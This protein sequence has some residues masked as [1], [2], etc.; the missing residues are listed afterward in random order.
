M[1]RALDINKERTHVVLAG[2]KI[3][4]TIRVDGTTCTEDFDLR[5]AAVERASTHGPLY[6]G[7]DVSSAQRETFDIEDVAW[8]N[9]VFS[10][11]IATAA[12]NGKIMLYDMKR[13]DVEV[14]RLHEHYRQVH[15]VD[16]NPIE[17]RFLLSGS[18]D[19]T[20][21][22]WDLRVFRQN[23]MICS[24]STF[25]GRSDGVRHVKWNPIDRWTFAF[26]T[27]NGTIQRWDTRKPRAPILT[28]AAHS[29]ICNSLD[30]HPDGK[31]LVS[32][33]KDCDVKV[34]DMS[35]DGS[36]KRKPA[37]QLRTPREVQNVRW[38]PACLTSDPQEQNSITRQC[39][40]LATS[41]RHM[42]V[43]H[44]WDLRRP[45]MPFREICHKQNTGTT[46]MLWRSK[47]L[48][49]T[50]GPEGDFTQTDVHYAPKVLDRRS[51]QTIA[52]S[53][54]GELAFF[55]SRRPLRSGQGLSPQTESL[56]GRASSQMEKNG[57]SP[58]D[59]SFEEQFLS[60]AFL[61]RHS[62]SPSTAKS[63]RSLAI[64]PPSTDETKERTVTE[65]DLTMQE[66]EGLKPHQLSQRGPLPGTLSTAISIYLAWKYK[67]DPFGHPAGLEPPTTPTL[68]SIA[69]IQEVFER[70]GV[71]AQRAS[72]YREAQTWRIL[73]NTL[74]RELNMR[75]ETNRKQRLNKADESQSTSR[76]ARPLTSYQSLKDQIQGLRAAETSSNVPTP[77]AR[78]VHDATWRDTQGSLTVPSELDS[79]LQLPFSLVGTAHIEGDS[80]EPKRRIT[81]HD[82]KAGRETLIP[83]WADSTVKQEKLALISQW[84]AQPKTPFSF[85]QQL[86]SSKSVTSRAP[87]DRQASEEDI[88][89]PSDSSGSH[90]SLSAGDSFASREAEDGLERSQHD[91]ATHHSS[92]FLDEVS[93]ENSDDDEPPEDPSTFG[94][95]VSESTSSSARDFDHHSRNVR[96]AHK[97]LAG[98]SGS[99]PSEQQSLSSRD[100]KALMEAGRRSS[101]RSGGAAVLGMSRSVSDSIVHTRQFRDVAAQREK[102]LNGAS[103]EKNMPVDDTMTNSAPALLETTFEENK[104]SEELLVSDYLKPIQADNGEPQQPF[105]T[106]QMFHKLLTWYTAQSNFQMASHLIL[107]SLP[108]LAPL[109][110][111]PSSD[112]FLITHEILTNS[113]YN[114][115]ID[116]ESRNALSFDPEFASDVIC[117]R[118]APLQAI[119]ISPMWVE[120][121]LSSY[122]EQ[123]LSLNLITPAAVLR[124]LAYPAFPAVYEQSLRDVQIGMLC[125]KCKNPINNPRDKMRCESCRGRQAECPICWSPE[126][127]YDM[128]ARKREKKPK[129]QGQHGPAA[130]HTGHEFNS[131]EASSGLHVYQGTPLWASCLL[132]GHA[133]HTACAFKWFADVYAH[134]AC[135]TIGCVCDCTTG[136]YRDARLAGMELQERLRSVKKPLRPEDT[137]P[138]VGESKTLNR[139]KGVLRP[140][141]SMS[142]GERDDKE[143]SKRVRM[144]FPGS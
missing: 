51:L 72:L 74:V 49:W 65:L 118:L 136:G 60:A 139:V 58:G 92:S 67:S 33:G 7:D 88:S 98:D 100:Q 120:T 138:A 44:V 95:S 101:D 89:F 113:Y 12:S 52:T 55:T 75:A 130:S 40:H 41:Y 37:Y 36:R 27:D 35:S 144:V 70:N 43:V 122:H 19:G 115:F 132:C 105:S 97:G 9:G 25:P 38:R 143:E 111:A 57:R 84:K 104:D 134:G 16:F 5:T 137:S 34:W 6:A 56:E 13:P 108:L 124:R 63:V 32:A 68:A 50:V 119:D 83:E 29:S 21:R 135:P 64:A 66:Y 28:I 42:P 128:P 133:A 93:A 48:L 87:L 91:S 77:L 80:N 20:V 15:K 24:S 81:A 129:T 110:F 79:E 112:D 109:G 11:H 76:A 46:D 45:Y 62:R 116:T 90:T 4:K 96:E 78:P 131:N 54:H 142:E 8:S 114:L 94:S 47:D 18:Q 39:T 71:N 127:P 53:P 85:D 117:T 31:H 126:T 3:L 140:R 30:W 1:L 69:G 10:N 103:E 73:G 82:L 59:D 123:L 106:L 2:R 102:V 61:K 17:G 22:L 125:T 23:M 121:I 107:M 86:A 14:A 26:G 141:G 99:S